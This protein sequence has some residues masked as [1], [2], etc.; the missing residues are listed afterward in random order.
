M[1]TTLL[2]SL[3]AY[4]ML[5]MQGNDPEQTI[6][7]GKK[8]KTDQV[9]T[10]Q[11]VM[12]EPVAETTG[13]TDGSSVLLASTGNEIRFVISIKNPD[14]SFPA[15]EVPVEASFEDAIPETVSF[16]NLSPEVPSEAAFDDSRDAATFT[17]RAYSNL[18]PDVPAEAT[19]EDAP[20]KVEGSGI[21]PDLIRSLAPVVPMDARF[22]DSL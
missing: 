6:P 19:F 13:N 15:P 18:T 16:K 10:M 21:N 14:F 5:I 20:L 12:Q 2:I 9:Q 4:V 22:D 3:I 11:V 1:K 8:A 7:S 17:R